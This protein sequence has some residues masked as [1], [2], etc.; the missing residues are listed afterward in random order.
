MCS[1]ASGCSITE[2]GASVTVATS[3][4]MTSKRRQPDLFEQ[5][6]ET[7]QNQWTALSAGAGKDGAAEG[8]LRV[9]EQGHRVAVLGA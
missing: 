9:P 3:A 4:R 8:V 7:G 1:T 5:S 2:N 6:T